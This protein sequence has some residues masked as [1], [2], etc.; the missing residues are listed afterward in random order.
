MTAY[1][2]IGRAPFLERSQE[3]VS[4]GCPLRFR[5]ACQFS[6][7]LKQLEVIKNIRDKF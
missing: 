7:S 2:K 6:T 4:L 5:H 3:V 1:L